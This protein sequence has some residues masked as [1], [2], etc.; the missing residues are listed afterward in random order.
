MTK[1][2][3]DLIFSI[4]SIILTLPLFIIIILLILFDSGFPI[5]YEQIRVGK[6]HREFYLYKF[7]TMLKEASSQGRLTVGKHD[8]RI[9]KTGY[10]LRKYKLDELPQL[11]NV[12]LG[13]MSIVGPRPEIPYYV[14]LYNEKQLEVLKVRPGITDL[15]SLEYINENEI[16]GT[17]LN[18]EE[19]YIST[20]M[21]AK[22]E[23]N[24]KYIKEQGLINDL[25]IILKTLKNIFN[26]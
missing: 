5:F 2:V 14:K 11:F 21:P 18:P 23:L 4:L 24:L 25:K 3:F 6:D 26:H 17:Y 7:R 9:T 16:L 10:Y 15:A 22:L 1:R 20:I 8:K 12:L 13:D 19:A